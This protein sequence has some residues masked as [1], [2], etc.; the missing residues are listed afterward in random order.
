MHM[1]V[2]GVSSPN[3]VPCHSHRLAVVAP[4][5]VTLQLVPFCSWRMGHGLMVSALATA[6]G[7]DRCL[8]DWEA[9]G[10]KPRT[11]N[12]F[13]LALTLLPVHG[14]I[15]SHL[16]HTKY[17][18]SKV[19]GA[20]IGPTWVLSAPG[21]PYVGPMQLAIWVI[22]IH[23]CHVYAAQYCTHFSTIVAA[24]G[25]LQRSNKALMAQM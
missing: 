7:G 5:C 17:P 13:I 23:Q 18:N 11:T 16:Y 2:P 15:L 4:M 25:S 14:D 22:S 1:S 9:L 20:I 24:D 19:H 3:G 6:V 8:W 12:S 10:T 21:G